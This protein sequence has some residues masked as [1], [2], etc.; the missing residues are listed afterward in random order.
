MTKLA[1]NQLLFI[2]ISLLFK[3]LFFS[4]TFQA[5]NKKKTINNKNEI[6]TIKP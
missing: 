4:K 1:A 3:I 5:L 6:E 2:A